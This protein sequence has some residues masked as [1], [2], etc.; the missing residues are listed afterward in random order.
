MIRDNTGTKR[1]DKPTR[2]WA[3][4][5]LTA[6]PVV[7]GYLPVGFAFGVLAQKSGVSGINTLCMSLFV[8]GGASQFIA[9]GLVAVNAP[10]ITI[11]ATT[12]IVNLR[13]VIM[14]S[15]LAP[16]LI[17]WQPLKLAA[18]CFQLTDETYALHVS[19]FSRGRPGQTE[20]L[21]ANITAHLAWLTG[22]GLG[23]I[24]GSAVAD[25]KPFALDY[26]LPALFIALIIFQIKNRVQFIVALTAG[27]LATGLSLAG[28]T[29]WNIILAALAGATVGIMIEPWIK[30]ASS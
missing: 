21:A 15:S 24:A 5:L 6:V 27:V 12:F 29:H 17:R 7:F 26:A 20:L 9:V 11:I 28:L 18:F 19:S 16:F 13:H 14:A 3:R 22:T 8:Y 1:S 2:P 10:A 25:V 4:G 30:R 23:V